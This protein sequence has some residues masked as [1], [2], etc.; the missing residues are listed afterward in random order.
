MKEKI[1]SVLLQ[2][3]WKAQNSVS[4]NA[5][6]MEGGMKAVREISEIEGKMKVID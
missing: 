5:E 4:S 3:R 1:Q 2:N 6:P